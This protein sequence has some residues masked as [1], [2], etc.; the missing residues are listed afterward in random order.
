[1]CNVVNR[2]QEMGSFV[3]KGSAAADTRETNLLV[4]SNTRK[5]HCSVAECCFAALACMNT[6]DTDSATDLFL[7]LREMSITCT[8]IR[9]CNHVSALERLH[10]LSKYPPVSHFTSRRVRRLCSVVRECMNK[11]GDIASDAKKLEHSVASSGQCKDVASR[12]G[13]I[14][15]KLAKLRTHVW[16]HESFLRRLVRA[17][18][19]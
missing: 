12:R 9:V 18:V 6:L 2:V 11:L 4:N 13:N 7:Y 14:A 17:C 10:V 1:M 15:R 19:A 8:S 5:L 16:Y 3:T